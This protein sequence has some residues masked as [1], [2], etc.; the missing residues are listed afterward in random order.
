MSPKLHFTSSNGS[1]DW[2]A[3]ANTQQ[4]ANRCC[5]CCYIQFNLKMCLHMLVIRQ[6]LTHLWNFGAI[7]YKNLFKKWIMC[8]DSLITLLIV[9]L[10]K[11]N[12]QF[13]TPQATLLWPKSPKFVFVCVRILNNLVRC[14]NLYAQWN[15]TNN[16]HFT[17]MYMKHS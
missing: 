3:S 4:M 16:T 10:R 15:M 6:K 7:K 1:S 14:R 11:F 2:L 12:F 13:V 17:Y 9:F 8:L 5:D